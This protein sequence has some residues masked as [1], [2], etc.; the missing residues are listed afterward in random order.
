MSINSRCC[1]NHLE[2]NKEEKDED[3]MDNLENQAK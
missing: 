2:N 3:F 1:K